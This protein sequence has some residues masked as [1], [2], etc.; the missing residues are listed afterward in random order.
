MDDYLKLHILSFIEPE[1]DYSSLFE[2]SYVRDIERSRKSYFDKTKLQKQLWNNYADYFYLDYIH[3]D[4][5]DV[6]TL[7]RI[8]N[9]IFTA[10][11]G[12]NF[13]YNDFM[14]DIL[15][16]S[17]FKQMDT[18]YLCYLPKKICKYGYCGKSK[19]LL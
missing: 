18:D 15:M 4:N 7:K 12:R 5:C 17:L 19:F 10:N 6:K 13:R 2:T 9:N 8:V 3:R 11:Y 14:D 1:F 16:F